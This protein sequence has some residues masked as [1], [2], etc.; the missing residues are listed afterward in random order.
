M[1]L[2][3]FIEFKRI[4]ENTG[5]MMDPA[6]PAELPYG[7]PDV[8]EEEDV[9]TDIDA[10]PTWTEQPPKRQIDPERIEQPSKDPQ[11]KAVYSEEEEG[12]Y[13]EI[14][15]MVQNLAN[16]LN[17]PLEDNVIYYTNPETNQEHEIEFY[18]DPMC[19]AINGVTMP[20]LETPEQ[21]IDYLMSDN[22]ALGDTQTQE[23]GPISV[24]PTRPGQRIGIQSRA[25]AQGPIMSE[26]R[27]YRSYKKRYR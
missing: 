10:P 11:R 7:G 26:R 15:T 8:Q 17:A 27:H 18:S 19:F 21:V 20:E 4:Y 13:S 1:K 3:R 6:D 12:D 25:Q 2:R 24:Q 23:P 22:G 16:D 14:D 5:S 9:D